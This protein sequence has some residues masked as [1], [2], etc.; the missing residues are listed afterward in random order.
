MTNK[1]KVLLISCSVILLCTCVIA[2]MSWALFSDSA[3]VTSHLQASN[4]DI[5]LKR[6]NLEYAV[7]DSDGYL[8]TQTVTTA[9]DLTTPTTGSVFGI[10]GT[11][12]LIVPGSYFNATLEIANAGKTAF[13]YSVSIKLNGTATE[14]SKQLKVTVMKSDN[15]VIGTEMLSEMASGISISAG[16]MKVGDTAQT[17]KVKVE[18]VDS[19]QSPYNLTLNNNAAQSG[20][21]NF[22][23]VVTATQST[24][25]PSNP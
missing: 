25:R 16:H 14:L 5:T 17:F 4:L 3:T 9:L 10:D 22:D 18:F 19:A 2:G 7:L 12:V 1:K 24:T 13:D 6:T 21:A 20:V 15:T 23:V 8:A 11:G